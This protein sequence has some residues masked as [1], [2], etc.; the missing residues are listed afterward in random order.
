MIYKIR[1]ILDTHE[2][3]FRD[4]EIEAHSTM[5]EFHNTIAQSFFGQ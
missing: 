4:V 5:E 2:D 3:I 1:I